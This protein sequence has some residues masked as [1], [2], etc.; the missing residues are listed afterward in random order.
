MKEKYVGKSTGLEGAGTQENSTLNKRIELDI[1]APKE[2]TAEEHNARLT[3]ICDEVKNLKLV[4]PNVIVRF[5]L[6]TEDMVDALYE[7][8]PTE[9]GTKLDAVRV[10]PYQEFAIVVNRGEDCKLPKDIKVGTKVRVVPALSANKKTAYAFTTNGAMF[11][12]YY[13]LNENLIMGRY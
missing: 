4:G 8:V 1:E 7:K 9:S 5:L 6:F 10:R 13:L 3:E 12:N 11:E 2:M